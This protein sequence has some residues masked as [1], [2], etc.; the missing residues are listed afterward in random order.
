V[1]VLVTGFE[2]WGG[3]REN[4]SAIIAHTLDGREVEGAEVVGV[5]VSEDFH[6]IP[7]AARGLL[8]EHKPGV[9]ISTGWDFTNKIKVEKFALN[10]M[11]SL[12]NGVKVSDRKG[13]HPRDL[14]VIPNAPI[15]YRAT[16]PVDS[17]VRRLNRAKIPAVYS[18][19][20][21]THCC[22]ALMYS[23]L[24]YVKEMRM[25]SLSGHMHVLPTPEMIADE[26]NSDRVRASAASMDLQRQVKA[27]EI[28]VAVSIRGLKP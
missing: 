13:N 6:E 3:L 1:L 22:N 11:D 9:I 24:H 18:Y 14:M 23:F 5:E 16:L 20:A 25:N 19:H 27:I 10:V 15:A 12:Y 17:I 21:F 28:A 26:K 2:S 7:R 8:R 4:P